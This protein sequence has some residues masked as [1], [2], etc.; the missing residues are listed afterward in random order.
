MVDTMEDT[1]MSM[2]Y[3]AK[4]KQRLPN[5]KVVELNCGHFVQEEE[6]ERAIEELTDF[7]GK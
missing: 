1:F 6:T 5:A 3:L 4:W 2:E 7:M